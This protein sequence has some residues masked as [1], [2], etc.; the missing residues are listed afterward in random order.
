MT[1]IP[2]RMLGFGHY[3]DGESASA[4]KNRDY[5]DHT[6]LVAFVKAKRAQSNTDDETW[7][8][9]QPNPTINQ[10]DQGDSRA[11]TA[12]VFTEQRVGEEPCVYTDATPSL[13]SRM[14]TGG[15]NTPMVAQH[16]TVPTLRSNGDGGIPSSRGEHII[17][18]AFSHT[19]GLDPQ[20][21][22]HHF[23]TLRSEG[24]GQAIAQP[25]AVDTYNADTD[26]ETF[27]TLRATTQNY[28]PHVIAFDSNWSNNTAS[29]NI[30][31][32][33]KVGSG[34]DIPSPPAVAQPELAVRRLTPLECERLMGW[35]DN[36]TLHRADGKPNSDS[37]R[38]RMC[39]NGIVKPVSQWIAKHLHNTLR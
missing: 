11:T 5:K 22:D 18:I 39:G 8:D 3:A 25:V 29:I 36:H 13:L 20:A 21:S 15:N 9:N 31:P 35:P 26:D 2:Y 24:G 19:Q 16:D 38:Y 28:Q 6:D 17:P 7:K 34:L 27:H 12:I 1:F 30:S 33:I 32:T 10:F 23:P 14:G 37:T 4:I